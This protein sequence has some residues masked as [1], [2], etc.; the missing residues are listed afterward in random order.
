MR[1]VLLVGLMSMTGL[2]FA[3]TVQPA[4]IVSADCVPIFG[5][6]ISYDC[7]TVVDN[8]G[9]LESFRGTTNFQK[10]SGSAVYI[11]KTDGVDRLVLAPKVEK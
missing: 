1:A 9:T 4:K 3:G 11:T 7:V 2:C 8:N 6:N 10:E 5:W